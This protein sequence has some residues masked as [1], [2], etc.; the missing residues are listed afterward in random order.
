M[1]AQNHL[2]L[3]CNLK[4]RNNIVDDNKAAEMIPIRLI[5]SII[6]IA[7]ITSM[8]AVAYYNLALTSAEH[9]IQQECYSLEAELLTM[10]SS[11]NA[12]DLFDPTATPGTTRSHTFHLSEKLIYLSF[13]VDPDQDNDGTLQTG[14]TANGSI[15]CYQTERGSK[16]IHWLSEKIC[17]R[18]G[19]YLDE[20]WIISGEEQG[21]I[22]TWAGESTLIF[23]LVHNGYT[24]YILIHATDTF[25]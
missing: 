23:E 24:P 12:R 22:L 19:T 16:H 5:I 10:T 13:G 11:G 25:T 4:N 15:L 3:T 20:R 17:F 2:L 21:F 7:A 18:E 8:V 1:E 14:L 9:Q 6:I